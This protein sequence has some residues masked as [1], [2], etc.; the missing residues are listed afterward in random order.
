LNRNIYLKNRNYYQNR[1]RHILKYVSVE[2]ASVLDVACGEMLLYKIEGS[3][4]KSYL[5][6]D[7]IDYQNHP[8]FI[9]GDILDFQLENQVPV[10]FIFL[11]GI[12]DHLN[13]PQK[14]KLL[15]TYK[16]L[17]SKKMVVSQFNEAAWYYN[18]D[19]EKYKTVNLNS[20][21]QKDAI[22]WIYLLKLPLLPYVWNLTN[23]PKWIQKA[24][25]ETIA[26]ISKAKL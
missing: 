20:Y 13:Y 19:L 6:I 24:S 18:K 14:I 1:I 15:D 22:Q 2:N 5:G 23:A 16:N 12:L 21:F 8:L 25:T 4:M 11:L 7:Q 26:L 3:R 17:F 10:D 9:H